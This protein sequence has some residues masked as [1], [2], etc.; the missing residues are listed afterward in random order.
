MRDWV[1]PYLSCPQS[2]SDLTLVIFDQE[3]DGEIMAGLLKSTEGGHMYPIVAGVPR[4]VSAS[5]YDAQEYLT[6]HADALQA[7]NFAVQELQAQYAGLK[8]NTNKYFGW[9]WQEFKRWGWQDAVEELDDKTDSAHAGTMDKT[10]QAFYR[11]GMFA[12]GELQG[13]TIFDGGSGNGRYCYQAHLAGARVLGMDLGEGSVLAAQE[14]CRE[15]PGVQI[16]QAD[17]HNPPVKAGALDGGFSIGVLM[18]TGNA[19]LAYERLAATVAPGGFFTAHVYSKGNIIVEFWDWVL[20]KFTWLLPMGGKIAFSKFMAA[21]SRGLSRIK[22]RKRD[23]RWVMN[24]F[25]E[26]R[27]TYHQMFD[28]WTAPIATHHTYPEVRKWAEK[29]G[30]SVEA[31]R[32]K[33]QSNFLNRYFPPIGVVTVKGRKK[34]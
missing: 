28:W 18:H 32:S 24:H 5:L 11:K 31:D 26:L 3:E 34:S 15:F 22:I 20:R 30:Y 12:E 16:F 6:K 27:N 10:N 23:M 17:L 2:K 14:N 25:V 1:L 33:K 13:K 9:E 8:K 7:E 19:A 29:A 21:I 4:F